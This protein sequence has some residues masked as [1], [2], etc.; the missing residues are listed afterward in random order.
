[1]LGICYFT[2]MWIDSQALSPDDYAGLLSAGSG[3]QYTGEGLME[4]GKNLHQV[5]KAFNTLHAGF[6]RAD[7]HP[8]RRLSEPARSGPFAGERLDPEKWEE[9]LD[10]YYRANRWDLET[11]WQT[12][13]SLRAAGLDEVAAKLKA[14]GRLK[15]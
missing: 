9:M 4:L 15:P 12:A 1:M 5:Q 10:E 7:D 11:G 8:P 14:Y 3:R 2:S 6:T 13:E